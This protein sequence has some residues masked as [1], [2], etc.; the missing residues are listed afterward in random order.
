M[1]HTILSALRESTFSPYNSYEV[2]SCTHRV[3]H[4]GSDILGNLPKANWLV[5]G[6]VGNLTQLV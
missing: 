2:G 6:E 5:T 4:F 3:G 1:P